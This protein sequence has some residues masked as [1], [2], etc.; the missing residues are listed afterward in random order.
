MLVTVRDRSIGMRWLAACLSLICLAAFTATSVRLDA[1]SAQT[2]APLTKPKANV[3]EL[4]RFEVGVNFA[5]IR[6]DCINSIDTSCGLPQFAIGLGAAYNLSSHFAVDADALE[7][8]TASNS[9]TNFY[10][11]RHAEY[12]VGL[13]TEGRARHYGYFLKTQIGSLSWNHVITGVV[14][15]PS[16]QFY[17]LFGDQRKFAANIAAGFEYSPTPRIHFRGE[18]G[19]LLRAFSGS[20]WQNNL[21]SMAGVY[22][23]IGKPMT[24]KPPVYNAKATHPFFDSANLTLITASVLGMTAD[25][26]TTQ[27]DMARGGVE[28]DPFARPLVKYGWSGQIA[29]EG[30]E[31]NA[32]VW[33]MY[34]LHRIHQH[35]I[36]RIAPAGVATAHGFFAYKNDK[37]VANSNSAP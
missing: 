4:P 19:D 16:G 2:T 8:P 29:A 37:G 31:I 12:M 6:T 28:S 33:G 36:E 5:D 34:G 35:W 23:G 26:I 20:V 18:I 3:A 30:I 13:R 1:Q 10:G 21:Q 24:W 17:F 14:Q 27:R 32:V 22:V 9:A 25:A 11:G 15:P 7:T